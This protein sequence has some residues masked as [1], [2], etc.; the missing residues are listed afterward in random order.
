MNAALIAERDRSP[1]TRGCVEILS[2][3][4]HDTLETDDKSFGLRVILNHRGS[5][6]AV[7]PPHVFC[8]SAHLLAVAQVGGNRVLERVTRVLRFGDCERCDSIDRK[9]LLLHRSD[10]EDSIERPLASG[11]LFVLSSSRGITQLMQS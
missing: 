11:R 6:R 4:W 9:A 8:P 7:R 1:C 10:L 2:R 5:G 3:D